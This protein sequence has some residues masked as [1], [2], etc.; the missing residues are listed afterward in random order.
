MRSG[1]WS[2]TCRGYVCTAFTTT[3]KSGEPRHSSALR[4]PALLSHLSGSYFRSSDGSHFGLLVPKV[5][6][7]HHV[8]HNRGN[9][10]TR[11]TYFP[12]RAATYTDCERKLGYC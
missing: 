11:I 12:T 10:M 6:R 7:T 8:H 5:L 4:R 3:E 1:D 2:G 9:R